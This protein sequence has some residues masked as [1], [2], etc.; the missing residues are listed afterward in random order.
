M[1]QGPSIRELL[2]V[3]APLLALS[4]DGTDLAAQTFPNSFGLIA[5]LEGPGL[6]EQLRQGPTL[7]IPIARGVE[8]LNAATATAIALYDWRRQI[9]PAVPTPTGNPS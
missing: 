1:E 9:G 4:A 3:N 5:G 8:S 2:S 7:R 6:P